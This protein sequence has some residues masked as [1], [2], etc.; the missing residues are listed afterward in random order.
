MGIRSQKEA[1]PAAETPVAP[2]SEPAALQS[3][4]P[5]PAEIE[6]VDAAESQ[7]AQSEAL[8]S[9]SLERDTTSHACPEALVRAAGPSRVEA[10]ERHD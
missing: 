1:V 2:R 7:E 10:I 3:V 6:Q 8:I 4:E 9:P 5:V